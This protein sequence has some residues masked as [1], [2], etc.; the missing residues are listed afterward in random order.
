M[1]GTN[2]CYPLRRMKCFSPLTNLVISWNDIQLGKDREF[3]EN[4][5]LIHQPITRLVVGV[6]MWVEVFTTSLAFPISYLTEILPNDP[7]L[8][9]GQHL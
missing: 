3:M 1:W 6:L 8:C 7:V 2:I 4:F 9:D 5:C